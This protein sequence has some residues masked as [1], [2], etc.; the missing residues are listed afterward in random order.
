M[1]KRSNGEG[2]IRKLENGTWRA[3]L[4]DGYTAEGKRRI[5]RFSGKSRK[6]VQEKIRTYQNQAAA[7]VR[8]DKNMTFGEFAALWYADYKS[9]VQPSTYSGYK[10][11]LALLKKQFGSTPI[12]E[13]LPMHIN[14][15]TDAITS[16]GY[17]SSQIRKC[18]AMLIQIFTAAEN[19]GL[20]MRNPALHAKKARKKRQMGK[21]EPAK[22]DAFTEAE[23]ER[24]YTDLP[25][26]LIGHGI[27]G[28]LGTGLRVQELIA[29]T[30]EDI[31][32]DGSWVDVNK[33]I[34]MVD[35]KP[36]LDVT[37]SELSTRIIPV[38][39]SYRSS[40]LY[41]RANGGRDRIYQPGNNPLYGVGSFRRRY[42]T[43]LK[44]VP[45]VRKLSPHCCRHTYATR[46]E[47][48]GV[49]L[50]V[51]ARLMGHARMETT[52]VYLHTGLDTLNDAVNVLSV[53]GKE[54]AHEQA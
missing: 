44:Q 21:A 34:E 49:P 38:P 53:T 12:C 40:F 30:A 3:E 36:H 1:A 18:R 54:A 39:E 42:Y 13:I 37:K 7:N 8:I 19:N 10:Y 26:D 35:G 31:A 47:K 15:Y 32:E 4:M 27:R 50:Q 16:Q 52:G 6:E 46:L 23:V 28:M 2:N 29:L 14:R 20:I 48:Q 22:K 17:S 25:Q 51:I 9:Q 45:G 24:L 5:V 33:A 41:L 11:T 43:A